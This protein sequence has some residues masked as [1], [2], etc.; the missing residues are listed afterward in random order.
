[1]ERALTIIAVGAEWPTFWVQVVY[2]LLTGLIFFAAIWGDQLRNWWASPQF[3]IRL[4]DPVGIL[5]SRNNGQPSWYFHVSVENRH[6]FTSAHATVVC[7]RLER[8]NQQGVWV[9][10]AFPG[11]LPLFWAYPDVYG[12]QR[13]VGDRAICDLGHIDQGDNTP[14]LFELAIRSN[15]ITGSVRAGQTARIHLATEANG[16][17]Q[18]GVV[19]FEI[20]WNGKWS[21]DAPTMFANVTIHDVTANFRERRRQRQ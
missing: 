3:A 9:E 4:N 7:T 14:F 18:R 8:M 17:V 2:T 15:N 6:R 13:V 1:M 20:T 21:D 11:R 12:I 16:Y 19:V 10:E 5:V